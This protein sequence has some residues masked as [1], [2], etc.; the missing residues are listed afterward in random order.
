MIFRAT[1]YIL[2]ALLLT[3][4]AYAQD[5][6]DDFGYSFLINKI[7]TKPSEPSKPVKPIPEEINN[8]PTGL[9]Q[10]RLKDIARLKGVRKNQLFAQTKCVVSTTIK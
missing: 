7:E 8:I 10:V 6:D 9:V 2:F 3:C 5:S 4:P 1:L